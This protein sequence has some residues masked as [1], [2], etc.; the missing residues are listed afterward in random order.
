MDHLDSLIP[1]YVQIADGLL[2]R[3]Q[4]GEL[5]PGN[6]LPPERELSKMLGVTRVTLRQALQN[7]ESQ[8][9]LVRQQ[10]SGTYVAEPK[11][12]REVGQLVPFT[13]GMER[14][15][16]TT[17]AKLI[18]LEQRVANAALA[19]Q[20]QI[21]ITAPVYYVHRLRLL[22]QEPVMLE[23]F[24]LPAHRVPG[25]EQHDLA[26]RSIYETLETEYGVTVSKAQQ[27]L[28]AVRASDYEANLLSIERGW[29]LMIEERLGFDQNGQPIEVAKDLYRGDR[30]RFVTKMVPLETV[31]PSPKV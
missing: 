20:L 24:T 22:N 30:F 28:E 17:G 11:V 21:P 3:I 29:P 9:L 14:R 16:Y 5:A 19:R 12:E 10:G 1:L 15:G 25:F 13:K 31:T 18:K 27:S 4:S 7:L 26:T 6:R 8:G 23:K 2:G